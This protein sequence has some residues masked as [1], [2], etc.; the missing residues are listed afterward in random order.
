MVPKRSRCPAEKRNG[1]S[2]IAYIEHA[3]IVGRVDEIPVTAKFPF[4]VSCARSVRL[5]P[6]PEFNNRR[7]YYY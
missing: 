3:R 6:R 7:Y 5:A 1:L 2:L 4:A